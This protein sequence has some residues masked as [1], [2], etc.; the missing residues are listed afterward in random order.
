MPTRHQPCEVW[1][2]LKKPV[3]PSAEPR[4][5]SEDCSIE[6]LDGKERYQPDQRAH[7]QWNSLPVGEVHHIVIEFVL[8]I[9]QADPVTAD[10]GH[11]FSNVEEVLEE[12]GS[13]VFVDMV[14]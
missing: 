11:G 1:T 13:D 8:I 3:R 10:I 9:P 12:F 6:H 4:Q 14:G 7:P 5:S 2:V